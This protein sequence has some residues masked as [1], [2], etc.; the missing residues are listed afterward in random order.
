MKTDYTPTHK[1]TLRD[2]QIARGPARWARAYANL[3]ENPNSKAATLI[4]ERLATAATFRSEGDTQAYEHTTKRYSYGT[5]V[6]VEEKRQYVT[7]SKFCAAMVMQLDI[8]ST[9]RQDVVDLFA[10][11]YVRTYR[12]NYEY[13]PASIQEGVYMLDASK[14]KRPARCQHCGTKVGS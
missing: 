6:L 5:H 14:L 1:R 4:L 11:K 10:G 9:K 2:G 12:R 8:S 13:L 7:C 3:M